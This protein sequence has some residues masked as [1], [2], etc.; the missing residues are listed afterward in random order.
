MT[1]ALAKSI[2]AH[3]KDLAELVMREPSVK[4]TMELGQPFLI[5]VGDGDTGIRIQQKVVGQ[6][7][8]RLAG[9]PMSSVHQLTLQDFSKAQAA[10]L[11]FFGAGD[12]ELSSN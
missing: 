8:V 10:V 5:I 6:Y 1:I 3:D 12:A 4:D 2:Q 7:I 9:I 11:S